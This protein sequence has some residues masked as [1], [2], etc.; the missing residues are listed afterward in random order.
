MCDGTEGPRRH[1]GGQQGLE[2]G[3]AE[4]RGP[5]E[6][7]ER[8]RTGQPLNASS[9]FPSGREDH[10]GCVTAACPVEKTTLTQLIEAVLQ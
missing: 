5:T 9:S 3:G 2:R 1:E 6:T 10:A 4:E 8:R 7:E